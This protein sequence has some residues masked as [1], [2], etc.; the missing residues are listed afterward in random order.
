MSL[1]SGFLTDK[2]YKI[3]SV[4]CDGNGQDEKGEFVPADIDELLE[5]LAYQTTKPSLQFSIRPLVK[6]KYVEKSYEKRRGAKRVLLTP[7]KLARKIMGRMLPAFIEPADL[8]AI[9]I[10]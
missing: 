4:L 8:D 2:Q 10:S 7:T 3:L 6:A 5:R 1:E 9:D